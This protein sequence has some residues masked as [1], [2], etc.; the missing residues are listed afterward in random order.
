MST[1]TLGPLTKPKQQQVI[2]ELITYDP[3]QYAKEVNLPVEELLKNL[4]PD[5][6]N[7]LNIDCLHESSLIEKIQTHFNLHSLLIDDILNDQRP[8]AE[9]YDDYLFFTLKMLH[10]ININKIE[11]EQ[12]SFVLGTNYLIS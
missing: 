10:S 1:P 12:I 4:K 5:Q 9:E 2:L 11:Y 8:K 3:D 7:W 6:V